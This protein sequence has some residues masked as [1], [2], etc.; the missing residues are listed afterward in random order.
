M[1]TDIFQRLVLGVAGTCALGIGLAITFTPHEFYAGYGVA[2]G[3]NPSLLS[4]LRGPGANLAALGVVILVGAFRSQMT[5]LSAALGA[6]LYLA[7]ASGR[8]MSL[9]VDGM[10]SDAILAAIAVELVIGTLC[11]LTLRLP[12]KQ[13]GA[14][15]PPCRGRQQNNALPA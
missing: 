12:S 6:I 11:A 13:N 14:V 1:S 8:L 10:P 3:T 5:R 2:L 9:A 15:R 4:E 7:F